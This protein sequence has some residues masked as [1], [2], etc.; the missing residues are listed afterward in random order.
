MVLALKYSKAIFETPR[1][2][3]NGIAHENYVTSIN[4]YPPR[5]T[6]KRRGAHNCFIN[7]GFKLL[8][9]AEN[10]TAET[11]ALPIRVESLLMRRSEAVHLISIAGT[12]AF[13]SQ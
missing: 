13:G 9:I 5:M 11:L 4:F 10:V 12:R 8:V 6:E 1:P 3:K 7:T 2:P